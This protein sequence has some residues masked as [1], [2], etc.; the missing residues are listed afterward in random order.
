[1][2]HRKI[3]VAAGLLAVVGALALTGTAAVQT[4]KATARADST[5]AGT[6]SE[7]R[8]MTG[9]LSSGTGAGCL[10][11]FS[12]QDTALT[13][14]QGNG[15]PGQEWTITEVITGGVAGTVWT[16]Y[17]PGGYD[18]G[19]TSFCLTANAATGVPDVEICNG[20]PLQQWQ[21][22]ESS[23]VNPDYNSICTPSP[24]L[25]LDSGN[26]AMEVNPP[27]FTSSAAPDTLTQ[28]WATQL[29]NVYTEPN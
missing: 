10:T 22:S 20:G 18:P 1:M 3:K 8:V 7:L 12:T 24:V 28:F 2:A 4:G 21:Y 14:C 6:N 5:E 26:G 27:N 19:G 11:A 15:A 29:D 16:I 13:P 9:L 17:A 23:F 25:C